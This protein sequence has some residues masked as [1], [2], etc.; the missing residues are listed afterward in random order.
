MTRESSIRGPGERRETP[1]GASPGVEL[2]GTG[3][4]PERLD[5]ARVAQQTSHVVELV[6]PAPRSAGP[7]NHST[8]TGRIRPTTAASRVPATVYRGLTCSR[9]RTY[10]PSSVRYQGKLSLCACRFLFDSSSAA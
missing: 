2:R 4:G 10:D 8:Q 3:P 7:A 5:P 1:E 9:G 6:S